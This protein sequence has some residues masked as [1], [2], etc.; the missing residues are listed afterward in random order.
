MDPRPLSE[1]SDLTQHLRTCGFRCEIHTTGMAC[2]LNA[3]PKLIALPEGVVILHVMEPPALAPLTTEFKQ[4]RHRGR[5]LPARAEPEKRLCFAAY[6]EDEPVGEITLF[7]AAGVAGIYYVEVT[8]E[9]RRRGIGAA[10]LQ[11]A[12]DRA[13]ELGFA[14]AV[15][16]ATR[17]GRGVYARAGFR[18]VCKMS[19]WRH[20]RTRQK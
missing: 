8:R 11:A 7:L 3:T 17:L 15:P 16:G 5:S 1:P 20:G 9:C 13:R 12:L 19:F 4:R 2:E 6:S 14:T 18:D 10:L